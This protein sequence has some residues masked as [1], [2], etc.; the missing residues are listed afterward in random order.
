MSNTS[1]RDLTFE[2]FKDMMRLRLSGLEYTPDFF[3]DYYPIDSAL[4]HKSTWQA[5]PDKWFYG[6][7]KYKYR[8]KVED[9]DDE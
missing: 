3:G 2:Q 7:S 8:I 4:E 9:E 6:L 1:Y 5:D